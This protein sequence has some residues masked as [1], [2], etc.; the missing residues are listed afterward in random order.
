MLGIDLQDRVALVVGGSR[1]IGRSCVE[2]LARA[3][4]DVTFTHTGNPAYQS[5]I[6]AFLDD[7]TREGL[8]VRALALD[9]RDTQGMANEAEQLI[10][11]HGKIDI[12]VHNAGQYTARPAEAVTAEEWKSCVDLNLTSAYNGVHAVLPHM[13]A[14]QYGRI[15]FIGSSAVVNGGG[16]AMDYAAAKAGLLGMMTY[17]SKEYTRKGIISNIIHPAVIETDL[18]KKRYTDESAKAS[19]IAQIPAGRLGQPEDIAGLVA[20]LASSWG[21]YICGQSFLVDGGRTLFR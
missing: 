4:A 19:L 11:D 7:M 12:L 14:R 6:A 15:I 17:L 13:V 5:E 16:G 10:A 2:T 8:A 3:G 21:D 18:L 9:A 20:F 1:G